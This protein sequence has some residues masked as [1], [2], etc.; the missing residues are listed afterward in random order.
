VAVGEH[1][2]RFIHD[3]KIDVTRMTPGQ[4]HEFLEEILESNDPRIRYLNMRVWM[5]EINEIMRLRFRLPKGS[6]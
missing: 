4:A 1:F 3:N 5:R 2:N 6:E